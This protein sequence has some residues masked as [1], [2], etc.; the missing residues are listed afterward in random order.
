MTIE[1]IVINAIMNHTREDMVSPNQ[2][3]GTDLELQDMDICEILMAV[4]KEVGNLP[5]Y[6]Y[7]AM[8]SWSVGGLAAWVERN[9]VDDKEVDGAAL[10]G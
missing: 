2:I 7:E 10:I 1:Q 9:R 3:L 6:D 8:R 4:E 5:D